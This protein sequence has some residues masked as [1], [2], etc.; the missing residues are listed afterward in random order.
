MKSELLPMKFEVQ[1]YP[2]G[3]CQ[4]KIEQ[5][6]RINPTTYIELARAF[7][8]FHFAEPQGSPEL[9]EL[10]KGSGRTQFIWYQI[11]TEGKDRVYFPF[12]PAKCWNGQYHWYNFDGFIEKSTPHVSKS[13]FSNKTKQSNVDF[14]AVWWLEQYGPRPKIFQEIWE[15]ACKPPKCVLVYRH[16]PSTGL[17]IMT[18]LNKSQQFNNKPEP[19][20]EP[21]IPTYTGIVGHPEGFRIVKPH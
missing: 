20:T 8:A 3:T 7:E 2:D 13:K 5:N 18:L 11:N 19:V 4:P 14:K 21:R 15:I 9:Y 1:V 6:E 10:V 12:G 17:P 16:N